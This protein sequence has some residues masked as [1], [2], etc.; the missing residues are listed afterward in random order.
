MAVRNDSP[1]LV[2]LPSCQRVLGRHP[3]HVVGR[4]YV[5]A[6][7]M[8]GAMPLMVPGGRPEELLAALDFIDGVLLIRDAKSA[9]LVR[10]MLIAYLPHSHREDMAAEAA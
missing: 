4:K 6:I 1:A 3:F 5:D 8:A 2:L 9:S 7:R 10:E